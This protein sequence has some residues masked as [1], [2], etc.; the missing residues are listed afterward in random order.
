MKLT[1]DLVSRVTDG[2]SEKYSFSRLQPT[3]ESSS[4]ATGGKTREKYSQLATACKEL[5]PCMGDE[6]DPDIVI[7]ADKRP[8]YPAPYV[9]RMGTQTHN[10]LGGRDKALAASNQP[11]Y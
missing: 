11:G 8:P 7:T 1:V 10:G 3:L 6:K 4:R 9:V 5:K 2:K